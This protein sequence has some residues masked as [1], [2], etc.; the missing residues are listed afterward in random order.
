MS[1]LVDAQYSDNVDRWGPAI[2]KGTEDGLDEAVE[3]L[4]RDAQQSLAANSDPWGG[5]FEPLSP[6][7]LRLYATMPESRASISGTLRSFRDPK[8]LKLTYTGKNYPVAYV[9]QFGNPNNRVF[10]EGLGPIPSRKFLPVRSPGA[11]PDLSMD[12]KI[13][14]VALLR[15]GITQA[16]ATQSTGSSRR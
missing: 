3:V 11:V 14:I 13:Q 5:A 12:V 15:R 16:I 1:I 9:K 4:R 2:E 7:T 6:V 10:D 8:R